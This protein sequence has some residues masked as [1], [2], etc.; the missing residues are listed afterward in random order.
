MT[1]ASVPPNVGPVTNVCQMSD[2]AT[3]CSFGQLHDPAGHARAR[4]LS[5]FF[6]LSRSPFSSSPNFRHDP[7]KKKTS[8]TQNKSALQAPPRRT[9]SLHISL[10]IARTFQAGTTGIT[11]QTIDNNESRSYRSVGSIQDLFT[12]RSC[13]LLRDWDRTERN[14]LSSLRSP[15]SSPISIALV[16]ENETEPRNKLVSS[17]N[18]S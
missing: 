15:S 6:F 7:K 18:A 5:H 4:C 17:N 16:S 2:R 14:I 13:P 11:N 12:T 10:L 8:E 3:L 1:G 9:K